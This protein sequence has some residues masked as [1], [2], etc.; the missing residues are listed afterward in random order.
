M[1]RKGLML[2]MVVAVVA[3][4]VLSYWPAGAAALPTF[5]FGPG[6]DG[7]LAALG[8]VMLLL[9]V[10]IQGWI[11]WATVQ[12]LRRPATPTLAAV[13]SQFN[14]GLGREALL[15]AAPLLITAVLAVLMFV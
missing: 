14:L 11:V 6:A 4:L 7:W 13:V 1:A 3:W 12:S 15:T 5:A 8:V 10:A 2:V 9:T